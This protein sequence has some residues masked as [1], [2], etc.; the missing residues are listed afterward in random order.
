MREPPRRSKP[1]ERQRLKAPR[2]ALTPPPLA[3]IPPPTGRRR[4]AMSGAWQQ[5]GAGASACLRGGSCR[6]GGAAGRRR[7]VA[8]CSPCLL[9]GGACCRGRTPASCSWATACRGP[10]V[11]TSLWRR[12][13]VCVERRTP[14]PCPCIAGSNTRPAWCLDTASRPTGRLNTSP[15]PAACC[16]PAPQDPYAPYA[17]GEKLDR[18]SLRLPPYQRRLWQAL[19]SRTTTPL[20]VVLVCAPPTSAA[21]PATLPSTCAGCRRPNPST[22][23]RWVPLPAAPG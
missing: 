19:A 10:A 5:L 2:S 14:R 9:L 6:L 13:A 11:T 15:A 12:Y 7:A 4:E 8:V 21:A 17:E 18:L 3:P 1:C 20:V 22:L 23:R 16:V